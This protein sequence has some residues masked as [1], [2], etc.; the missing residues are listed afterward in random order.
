MSRPLRIEFPDAWYHVM[1][2]ARFGQEVFPAREDYL[3]FI[4]LLM[5]AS[6]MFNMRVAAYCLMSTH[7]TSLFKPMMQIYPGV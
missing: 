1:N 3:G 7:I 6:E 5:D 4:D 2:R